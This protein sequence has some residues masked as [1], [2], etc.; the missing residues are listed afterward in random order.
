V[1]N[2]DLVWF[3][4]LIVAINIGVL[5]LNIKL[6]TEIMKARDQDRRS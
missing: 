2:A 4:L 6:Y 3:M 1:T 5:G